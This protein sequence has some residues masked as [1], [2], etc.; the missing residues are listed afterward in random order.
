M[1]YDQA[2]KVVFENVRIP[3]VGLGEAYKKGV[4]K[5]T[6]ELAT[7]PTLAEQEGGGFSKEQLDASYQKVFGREADPTGLKD[8]GS[9]KW[10]GKSVQDLEKALMD[11]DE[12]RTKKT[13]PTTT[14]QQTVK[15]TAPVAQAKP[16]GDYDMNANTLYNFYKTKLP[17]RQERAQKFKEFGL[18]ET[19]AYIGTADQNTQ[20]LSKLKGI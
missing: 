6:E 12:Y 5:T 9:S 15:P 1:S 4:I 2:K 20:L 19:S 8:F 13:Q 10:A 7:A 3:D 16:T 18:G 14:P 11:S 17:S